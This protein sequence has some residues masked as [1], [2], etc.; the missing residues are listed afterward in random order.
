MESWQDI[1]G[2]IW[3]LPIALAAAGAVVWMGCLRRGV[4][5]RGPRRD[6]G[7]GLFDLI[8]GFGLVILGMSVGVLV[9][10][11]LTPFD[12]AGNPAYESATQQ[13]WIVLLGQLIVYL[14]PSLY[15]MWRASM[16]REGWRRVGLRPAHPASDIAAGAAATVLALPIVLCT[17]LLGAA[18]RMAMGQSVEEVGHPMLEALLASDAWSAT[19]L[20]ATSAI[21]VAPVVEEVLY[22]GLLQTALLAA[23]PGRRWT[24]VI[25][26]A[27]AFA[28]QHAGLPPHT[29]PGLFILGL[30]L[31]WLY[32]RTGSLLAPIVLHMGF[33]AFNFV[34]VMLMGAVEA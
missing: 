28:L 2:Q 15:M 6:V 31:G 11:R 21:I 16:A 33:N 29:L 30:F 14:P 26:A 12:D 10:S 27:S 18:A 22:R 8:A 24:V 17:V 4:L 23:M 7:F 5:K 34:M 3:I 19:L 13:A 32:E 9:I 1:F 20:M 25:L